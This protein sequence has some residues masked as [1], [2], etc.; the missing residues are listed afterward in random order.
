MYE[1]LSQ[2]NTA[3]SKEV[4]G[5]QIAWD[6]TSLGLFKACPRKYQLS[7]LD[8]WT[9]NDTATP[10]VFG[11]RY[12]SA[13]ETY[14]KLRSIGADHDEALRGA[15]RRAIQDC[16][17]TNKSTGE[18]KRWDPIDKKTGKTDGLR[19][20]QT[21]VRALVWYLEQFKDDAAKTIILDNGKPA[22]ELSFK[23]Q[24]GVPALDGQ[25]YLLCGHLDRLVEFTDQVYVMDRK[26]TKSTLSDYYFAGFDP[27][28]QMS[29]YTLASRVVLQRP[30]VGVILDACQLAVGFARF[31][32]AILHRTPSQSDE[33]LEGTIKYLQQAERYAEDGYWPMNETACSMYGGCQFRGVC[34]TPPETRH[35]ILNSDFEKKVWDPLQVRE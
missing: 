12:H 35:Y 6:S 20:P 11:I 5:L 34:K 27:D 30:A 16:W 13:L 28:N 29:L 8:Q 19:N 17:E 21:L 3:F 1:T 18:V 15:V 10:L 26:T 14:D 33:W 24:I 23:M 25:E 4:P 22:V 32:R 31:Q 9:P 7:M 2:S